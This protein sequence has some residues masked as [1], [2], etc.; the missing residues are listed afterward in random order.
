MYCKVSTPFI[1]LDS[2]F[3]CTAYSLR[4]KI[5]QGSTLYIY[6]KYTISSLKQVV[7]A[8]QLFSTGRSYANFFV[9]S[10]Q[11]IIAKSWGGGVIRKRYITVVRWINDTLYISPVQ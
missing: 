10:G 7:S 4:L 3:K 9:M 1:S 8:P 6:C 2:P 11:L 5:L